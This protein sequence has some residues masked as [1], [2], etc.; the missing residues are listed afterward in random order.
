MQIVKIWKAHGDGGERGVGPILGIS[1]SEGTAKAMSKGK[2]FF[3]ADGS[4]WSGSAIENA[5]GL[6]Y[7]LETPEPFEDGVYQVETK[8]RARQAALAKLTD[9]DLLAL[10]IK[11]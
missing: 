6:L 1:K 11:R 5:D 4:V 9:E 3:G 10:G 8:D 2:A 7:L